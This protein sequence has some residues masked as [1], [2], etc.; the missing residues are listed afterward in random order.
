MDAKRISLGFDLRLSPSLQRDNPL[1]GNQRL[2]PDLGSPV[3]ADPSVWLAAEEIAPFSLGGLPDFRNPLHLSKSI[4]LL[5]D[6]CKRR[7]IPLTG[8]WPVC[9]TSYETNLLALVRRYGPGYFENQASEEELQSQGW[10]FMGLDVLDLD[11][12]ISGLKGCGYVEPMWSQLRN[13][14]ADSLNEVGLFTE[15]SIASTFAEVRGLEIRK[16]A[17]FVVVGVLTCRPMG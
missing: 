1:Q 8:L 4:D 9:V 15:A 16:H 2:E 11:G 13:R 17:P 5:V 12:L 6:D 14:F 3:S 7:G 10:R